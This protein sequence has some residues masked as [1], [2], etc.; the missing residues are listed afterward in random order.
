MDFDALVVIKERSLSSGKV[1]EKLDDR[2]CSR[3]TVSSSY[4]NAA[5]EGTTRGW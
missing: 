3:V 1:D 4:K 2:F 5:L